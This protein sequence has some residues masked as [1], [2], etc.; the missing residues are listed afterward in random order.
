MKLRIL[1]GQGLAMKTGMELDMQVPLAERG[2][3]SRAFIASGGNPKNVKFH[4]NLICPRI[5]DIPVEQPR[6]QHF[7]NRI[8]QKASYF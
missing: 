7:H 4:N 3:L 6:S 1:P 5:F 2:W 8:R